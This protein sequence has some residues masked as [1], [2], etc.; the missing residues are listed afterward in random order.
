MTESHDQGSASIYVLALCAVLAF[1][2]ATGVL[3]G[4]AVVARHRAG[5]AAELAA[6]AAA[7]RALDG[8]GVACAAAGR[9]AAATGG[10]MTACALHDG[11]SEV[12]TTVPMAGVLSAWGPARG[13]AR[14]GPA[15]VD[16]ALREPSAATS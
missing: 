11:V 5:A 9:V 16:P 4:Q 12:V 14:A 3:L 10:A 1:V 15:D 2:A 6:L 7:D 8:E 13:R